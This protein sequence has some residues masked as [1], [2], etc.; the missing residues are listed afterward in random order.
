MDEN[1]LYP[2]HGMRHTPFW[3]T[4]TFYVIIF[5]VGILLLLGLIWFLIRL[6]KRSKKVVKPAWEIALEELQEIQKQ[7]ADKGM[8]GKTFY[9][10]LTWVFKRYLSARYKLD[11][12]GKT[13]DELLLYLE[14]SGLAPDL[15]QD[16]SVIFEGSKTIKFA[17]E[18]AMKKRMERDIQA[19]IDFIEKTI[20]KPD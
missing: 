17:N 4:T 8:Q 6:Y 15:A 16:I 9:F 18:Q 19:S 3:Q 12:Y 1:T 10:R 5:F 2:I 14:G 13:D 11:V 7:L 20:P